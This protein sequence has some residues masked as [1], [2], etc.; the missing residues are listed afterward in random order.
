[1]KEK[2]L[3]MKR[4]LAGFVVLVMILTMAMPTAFVAAASETSNTASC[5]RVSEITYG[6]QYLLVGG[7]SSN[8]SQ[9]VTGKVHSGS[10]VSSVLDGVT[11]RDTDFSDESNTVKADEEYLWT[12]EAGENGT[13]SLYNESLDKY[14]YFTEGSRNITL[15]DYPAYYTVQTGNH[16]KGGTAFAFCVN[17]YYLN[18][19]DSQKGFNAYDGSVYHEDV[20]SINNQIALY[21]VTDKEENPPEEPENPPVEPEDDALATLLLCSDFQT[22]TEVEPYKSVDDVPESLTS[23]INNVSTQIYNAGYTQIDNA[24]CVGDY[25]AFIGRYNY[26]AD[27]TYGIQALKNAI[28]GHWPDIQD[29]LFVQGNHDSSQYAYDEGANEY[30]DYIVYC[31]NTDYKASENGA[32]PWMQGAVNAEAKVKLLAEKLQSYLC[33]L[34]E[35]GETRPVFIMAH[36]PMHFSG[37]TSSLYGN[38]DNVYASYLF[39]VINSAAESLNIVYVY[40]HN[41]SNGWDSYIGGSSVF[42]QAGDTILI[43]DAS[44]KNGS[45]TDKY[46]EETLNFCYMN[47]GYIGY[48]HDS[49][50]DTALTATVCQI[51]ED[52]L[53]FTRFDEN[54]AHLLGSTGSYNKKYD[55]SKLIEEDAVSSEA[56]ESPLSWLLNKNIESEVSIEDA[57]GYVGENAVIKASVKNVKNSVLT[58]SSSD[59]SAVEIVPQGKE[60]LVFCKKEGSVNIKVTAAGDNGVTVSD[61][62]ALNI[63][64]RANDTGEAEIIITDIDGNDFDTAAKGD[65]IVLCAELRNIPEIMK[66]EWSV[67]DKS[68]AGLSDENAYMPTLMM[69]KEGKVNV[70]LKILYRDSE[71]M[72][73]TVTGEK[74][75][76]IE[77]LSRY[78]RA[79]SIEDGERYLLI[80]V[81][82]GALTNEAYAA[83]GVDCLRGQNIDEIDFDKASDSVRGNYDEF[84]WTITKSGDDTYVIYNE[85]AEKYL[86]IS[87]DNRNVSLS[88]NPVDIQ[89]SYGLLSTGNG[90]CLVISND[91]MYLNYSKSKEGYCGYSGGGLTDVNN[92]FVAYEFVEDQEPVSTTVLE[93]ALSLAETADTE[94]VV[95]S[96]VKIFN[97]A[98]AA[99]E[100][101]LVR[102][103]AGDTSVTQEMVDESWQNLIKAMQ[104]LSFKQGNKTDLQ[105]VIDMAKSLDLNVYLDEGQQ[106][107]TDALA[108]AEAVLANGDA[109]QEEV[110]QSWKDLLKAMSELR[111]KPNKDAL[112]DLID[113]AN[114]MSTEGADEETIAVFQNALAAA[115]SVYDNEQAT[116]E[117]VAAAEEG[118]Q[119]ALDQLRAA[120]GDTEDPDNSGNNSN[121][122]SGGSG[123]DQNGQNSGSSED[124]SG[125]DNASAQ[126]DTAKNSS[127][128]KSVKT[129]DTAAPIAGMAAVMMLAAAAGVMAYRRRRETR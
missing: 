74:N 21:R 17:N 34:I 1:M 72:E 5:T 70:Q 73:K 77:N 113:E 26:D 67:S 57:E 119:A 103:Q 38:G 11:V 69:K 60:A 3:L 79:D 82:G 13:C 59:P 64:S 52:K 106:A 35:N 87:S 25:S 71:G 63:S 120:V 29:F 55:D 123:Q 42:K 96:V 6:E 8:S 88:E 95:D 102:V 107:F 125:K 90:S 126:T 112:K 36:I 108:A 115:M 65:R 94:G 4:I 19:S 66:Y 56:T 127:A 98:K 124:T 92:Q 9:A 43:P 105:K 10:K 28:Q 81:S 117:V 129:G 122:G 23:V 39:D 45:V 22:G 46:T 89:I 91:S 16:V 78:D 104:Y 58:W 118:L 54:G 75:I 85:K 32:Y 80:G 47:A 84:L 76:M 51:L 37:R 33:G 62:C 24:L 41:H 31:I 50:S 116:E 44:Q 7:S 12:I 18:Y 111:L 20:N 128:Q 2:R 99:A 53:V 40:G 86:N 30:K 14:L 121:T 101:I 83:A 110:D 27:P 93:Y 97:D 15:E 109:M 61:M 100:D 48:N 68:A 114:G 49:T